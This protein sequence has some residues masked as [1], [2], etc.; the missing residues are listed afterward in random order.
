MREGVSWIRS[1]FI[2]VKQVW[3]DYFGDAFLFF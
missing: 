2:G 3:R 1:S